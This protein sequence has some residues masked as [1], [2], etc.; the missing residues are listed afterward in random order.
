[1][2]RTRI[3]LAAGP[4]QIVTAAAA[5]EQADRRAGSHSY[6]NIL[7]LYGVN[8]KAEALV[9]TMEAVA[10]AVRSWDRIVWAIDTLSEPTYE[11]RW[12]N[13]L[14]RTDLKRLLGN[15]VERIGVVP[16][17]VAELFVC[18]LHTPAEKLVVEAYPGAAIALY[19]EGLQNYVSQ[20]PNVWPEFG[21][22]GSAPREAFA[23]AAG[24]LLTDPLLTRRIFRGWSCVSGRHLARVQAL[25]LYIARDLGVAEPYQNVPLHLMDHD[26]LRTVIDRCADLAPA[27]EDGRET[28]HAKAV[29]V[30]GQCYALFDWIT[31]DREIEVYAGAVRALLEQGQT[32]LWKDHP[33]LPQSYFGEIAER[34]GVLNDPSRFRLAS[35]PPVLPVEFVANRLGLA[36]CVAGTSSAL[37]YLRHL[38]NIPT[39]SFAGQFAAALPRDPTIMNDLVRGAIPPIANLGT[40]PGASVTSKPHATVPCS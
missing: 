34:C 29:L 3:T 39:F 1:L 38:Y 10:A 31:R 26:V 4:W 32:V 24:A 21:R 12:D 7:V 11:R 27:D 35:L 5:L 25:Y 30:L 8:P 13:H 15:V 16:A 19:E 14:Y 18:T 36:G 20:R 6:Q 23:E 2:G 37:F 28:G 17:E 40:G 33:R 9:R 22:W